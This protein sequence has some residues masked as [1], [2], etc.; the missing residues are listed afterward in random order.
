[1]A[2]PGTGIHGN[3][4][5]H[6]PAWDAFVLDAPG[7][8][9]VQTSLWAQVKRILGWRAARIILSDGDTIIAGAQ[10]LYRRLT[11][12]LQVGY[13][14]NGP[15]ARDDAGEPL[16]QIVMALCRF[17]RRQRM[18]MLTVQPP[19]HA[20]ALAD[21]LGEWGFLPGRTAVA[22]T[23]SVVLDLSAGPE[24]ILA[25]MHATTRQNIKRGLRKGVTVRE[26]TIEDVPL[27]W[28]LHVASSQRQGF[29]P[30]P[31]Q[32]FTTIWRTLGAHGYARLFIARANGDDVSAQL[33]VPFADTVISKSIGWSGAHKECQP[34]RVLDWAVIEWAANAGYRRFD[35]EGIDP[36]VARAILA[37]QSLPVHAHQTPT[38]YKLGFGGQV[39][40]FPGPYDYIY[41]PALR[42]AYDRGAG[43][44]ARWPAVAQIMR[45]VQGRRSA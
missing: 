31:L 26:G 45:R 9:H 18:V 24:R 27:F 23:A 20:S 16:T 32:Y 15:L 39:A 38:T 22:P 37:G 36:G 43:R 3:S 35:L 5:D 34:N 29:T 7:G 41:S 17:S 33:V 1:M 8:H 19:K 42:W 4:A 28:R 6:D 30:Y 21:R 14:T 44:L 25:G 2:A 12:L 40:L 11:P 13:V 10:V